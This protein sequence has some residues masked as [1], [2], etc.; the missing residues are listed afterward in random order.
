MTSRPPRL[1]RPSRRSAL[2]LLAAGAASGALWRS[3]PPSAVA[4]PGDIPKRLIFFYTQQGTLRN[5]WA[6]TGTETSFELGE[7]HGPLQTYKSDLLLLHG[8]DMRSND[9]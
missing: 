4:A 6:P 7:L 5:L 2:G 1:S 9:V 3:K 8:L